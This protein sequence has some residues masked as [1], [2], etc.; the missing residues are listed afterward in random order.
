MAGSGVAS[1]MAF[2][3]SV[4]QLAQWDRDNPGALVIPGHDMQ[5]WGQ[6][7]ELYS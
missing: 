7:E 4:A 3:R 5:A 2:E 6:L 1:A